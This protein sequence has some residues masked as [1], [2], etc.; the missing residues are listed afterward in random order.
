MKVRLSDKLLLISDQSKIEIRTGI[1]FR[2]CLSFVIV[3]CTSKIFF[4]VT[5]YYSSNPENSPFYI[6]VN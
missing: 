6:W 4:T 2:L 5:V 3:F 1:Y